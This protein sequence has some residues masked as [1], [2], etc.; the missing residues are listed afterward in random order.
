M[1]GGLLTFCDLAGHL[2][3]TRSQYNYSA[4]QGQ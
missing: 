1:S 4:S 3:G 2:H